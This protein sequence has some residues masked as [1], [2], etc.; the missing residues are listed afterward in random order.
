MPNLA[1]VSHCPVLRVEP[2]RWWVRS[3]QERVGQPT[4]E[5]DRQGGP[6]MRCNEALENARDWFLAAPLQSGPIS[7]QP[8]RNRP[9]HRSSRWSP[10][11][12]GPKPGSH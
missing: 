7:G 3:G 2:V 8:G 12:P 9:L 11:S 1:G 10:A 5:A 6:D 4:P